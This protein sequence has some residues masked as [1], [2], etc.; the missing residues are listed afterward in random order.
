MELTSTI[1]YWLP[2]A[3]VPLVKRLSG[4]DNQSLIDSFLKNGRVPWS[5]GYNSYK[6]TF[7]ADVLAHKAH[8]QQW[9]KGERLP[10]GYG[11]GLD[12]RCV[13]YPW[14][15]ANLPESATRILDAGSALNFEHLV[16]QFDLSRQSLDIVTLA[17]E[18]RCFW[19]QG[20]SYLYHDL[21]CLPLKNDFYSAIV[22]LSTIE[23]IGF[24]NRL[25]DS[26]T[27]VEDAPL[28]YLFAIQELRRD[29]KPGGSLI[30]RVPYGRYWKFDSYQK[31][32]CELLERAIETFSPE[33]YRI[34]F[35]RYSQEGWQVSTAEDCMDAQYVEWITQ[36]KSSKL[37]KV[38]PVEPD[39]AAAA[40]A[41]ACI[42]LIK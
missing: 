37:P 41:V 35:Y 12:E 42:E 13:E 22:S 24:D 14:A 39:K 17:P 27:D 36:L 11:S 32:D 15:F 10:I 6:D 33:T 18:H 29:L 20:I 3:I 1:Q 9:Q 23:H 4:K 40:R 8:W 26:N 31:F 7:I 21:R 5:S 16:S 28:D 34:Y 38:L 30:L 25:Y 19:Q 2:S